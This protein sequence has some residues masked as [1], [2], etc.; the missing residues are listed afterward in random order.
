V[1]H[2]RTHFSNFLV[3]PNPSKRLKQALLAYNEDDILALKA[4]VQYIE[5]RADRQ[6]AAAGAASG[7]TFP[8]F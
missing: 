5:S 8:L 3:K 7:E 1:C 2:V 6:A 4:V